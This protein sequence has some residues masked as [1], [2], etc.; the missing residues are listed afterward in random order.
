[1]EIEIQAEG[2]V[3]GIGRSSHYALTGRLR[4]SDDRKE[5]VSV[6]LMKKV[7]QVLH[8]LSRSSSSQLSS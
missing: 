6:F 4:R 7:L 8:C 1:M 2:R 3:R 5:V